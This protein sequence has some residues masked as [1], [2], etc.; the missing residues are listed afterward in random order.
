MLSQTRSTAETATD[1]TP[2]PGSRVT[3]S[4]STREDDTPYEVWTVADERGAEKDAER[5]L[6]GPGGDGREA[7]LIEAGRLYG[8]DHARARA[9][10]VDGFAARQK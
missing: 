2:D 4:G 9:A 6:G 8:R 5:L 10:R 7:A 3:R 1:P